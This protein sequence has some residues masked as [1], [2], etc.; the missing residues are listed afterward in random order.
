MYNAD[1]PTRA[2]LP[3]TG[4]LLRSTGIALVTAMVLLTTV[5]LPAEYAIDPTGI[6]RILGLTQM[7]E[8]KEQ[9]AEEA[10]LD[11]QRSAVVAPVE[12]VPDGVEVDAPEEPA[13]AVDAAAVDEP[14]EPISEWTDEVSLELK[15]GEAA[16]IKLVMR[17]GGVVE[18]EW[19]AEPGHLNSALHGDGTAGQTTT[20]RNGRAEQ[21]HANSFT[22][23]FDGTHGWFWRNRSDE[24]VTM[25]LRVR[26]EYTDIK[27]VI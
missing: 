13:E 12:A 14:E 24:A 10:A 8:I 4:Q 15:P 3:T 9:L 1:L 18:F 20:Y 26:G 16:E 11:A 22:A 2:D 23:A 7:G 5:I 17:S 19:I 25:T 21:K 27:R 6:G